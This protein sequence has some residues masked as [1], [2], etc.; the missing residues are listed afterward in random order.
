VKA[1]SVLNRVPEATSRPPSTGL[2]RAHFRRL[3]HNGFGDSRNSYAHS[4]NWFRGRLYVG[5]TRNIFQLVSIAPDPSTNAFHIWPVP[6]EDGLDATSLDQRC[7]IWRWSPPGGSWEMT[8][9][10]PRVATDDGRHQVWRDFGYRTM[11][12]YRTEQDRDET[13]YVSTMASSKAPGALI[14]RSEDGDR[15]EPVCE[16]GMI[17]RGV[18]SFRALAG[19]RGRLFAAPSGAGRMWASAEAIGLLE[20]RDLGRREWAAAAQAGFGDRTSAGVFELAVFNDHLYAGVANPVT[21]IQI[22]KTDGRG[23]APYRWVQVLSHGAGR[24]KTNQAVMSMFPFKDH[25]YIGTG[26]RRGGYDREFKTGPAA[27]ELLRIDANDRWELVAGEARH[28]PDGPREPLSGLGPGFGN[29]FTGYIWCMAE[30]D[31]ALY[32]GTY[33]SSIF[34]WWIDPDRVPK[35]V[36]PKLRLIGAQRIV[37]KEAGF[38]LWR[39]GDG[40]HWAEVSRDGFGNPYN[41]GVRTLLGR[42]EGLY[43]GTANPFAPAVAV[44]TAS[45]WTYAPNERGGL[46]IWMGSRSFAPETGAPAAGAPGAAAEAA[47]PA[48]GSTGAINVHYDK[49]MYDQPILRGGEYFSQTRFS[50]YGYW[51]ENTPNQKEACEN[52]M[53]VMLAF[54]SERRGSVLDVA[55][56]LGAT[57]R[58]FSRT[59]GAENITGVN[60]SEKQLD[61]CR[62]T[63]PGC[64]FLLMDATQLEFDDGMFD[65][66]FCVEAAFHFRTRDRFLREAWRV[67]KPKGR[68]VL[69]DMLFTETAE[70]RSPVLHPQNFVRSP[71][72]YATV[73]RRAGFTSVRVIDATLESFLRCNE[74]FVRYATRRYQAGELDSSTF[75]AAM[76]NRLALLLSMRYYVIA[77]G[78]KPGPEAVHERG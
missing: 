39:S 18:T 16:R 20:S 25:L 76:A 63:A 61:T 73:L 26:I 57:S 11:L 72:A 6:V 62:E 44:R 31:G 43:L 47:S 32:V 64:R 36:H 67:L 51:D 58:H 21:G 15:F 48:S 1:S 53:E 74:H 59:F 13:L 45:G 54:L 10:S 78:T 70:R 24:G 71:R 41:Y 68:L 22:W 7:Q 28:T 37:D 69:T 30:H 8:F 55:C 23:D 17:D 2:R 19:F 33:D 12:V 42:P 27:A 50:N 40:V 14:L 29:P 5:T 60:I 56:G 35:H 46:E 77:G 65:V 34:L 38:D 4:M 52:L 9:E 75:R 49:A 3:A 66:V